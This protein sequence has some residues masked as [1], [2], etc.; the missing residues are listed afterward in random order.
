MYRPKDKKVQG[1]GYLI[2]A[3]EGERGFAVIELKRGRPTDTRDPR[4]DLTPGNAKDHRDVTKRCG[5]AS[6]VRPVGR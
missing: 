2:V 6:E 5:F 4:T 3:G 1:G